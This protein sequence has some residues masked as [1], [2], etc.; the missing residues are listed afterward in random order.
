MRNPYKA[1]LLIVALFAAALSAPADD[2]TAPPGKRLKPV[3]IDFGVRGADC[4]ILDW[5]TFRGV[6][7]QPLYT[8][9][10]VSAESTHSSP[11]DGDTPLRDSWIVSD[12]LVA[13]G[14]SSFEMKSLSVSGRDVI[15]SFFPTGLRTDTL[16]FGLFTTSVSPDGASV[17]DKSFTVDSWESVTEQE[18]FK[19]DM[20]IMDEVSVQ[21]SGLDAEFGA[22]RGAVVNVV[23]KRGKSTFSGEACVYYHTGQCNVERREVQIPDNGRF[24]SLSP[25]GWTWN[26]GYIYFSLAACVHNPATPGDYLGNEL[27]IGRFKDSGP[28]VGKVEIFRPVAN[29]KNVWNGYRCLRFLPD[30]MIDGDYV[31]DGE[32]K[33]FY[34]EYAQPGPNDDPES[35]D[36]YVITN[37]VAVT[38]KRGDLIDWIDITVPQW[39][40]KIAYDPDKDYAVCGALASDI[41][42][43]ADGSDRYLYLLARHLVRRPDACPGARAGNDGAAPAK[44]RDTELEARLLILDVESRESTTWKTLKLKYGEGDYFKQVFLI[45]RGEDFAVLLNIYRAAGDRNELLE[46][47]FPAAQ[48]K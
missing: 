40:H 21:S 24:R 46:A 14:N 15:G 22:V 18:C 35:V 3:K 8:L 34:Q 16:N 29:G 30:K 5:S 26:A 36:R 27:Y 28:D 38:D 2:G 17:T 44:P 25:G 23:T 7:G 13:A 39:K 32:Q 45:P 12:R 47:T 9:Y 6:S 42:P 20:D 43:L 4:M 41:Y 31:S 37:S 11:A 48:V 10:F 33:L 1:T 19:F